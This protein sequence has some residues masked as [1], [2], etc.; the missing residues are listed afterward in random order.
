MAD[1]GILP[2]FLGERNQHGS[3]TYGVLLS[4]SGVVCLGWLSFS[5]VVDM[6][7]LLFCF[8]QAIE[9]CAFLHLRRTQPDMPRPFKIGVGLVGMCVMLA[10]PLM[11][12]FVIISFSSLTSLVIS[13]TLAALG[14]LVWYL[15]EFLKASKICIFENKPVHVKGTQ[16]IELLHLTSPSPNGA[17]VRAWRWRRLF[18]VSIPSHCLLR[19]STPLDSHCLMPLLPTYL[20]SSLPSCRSLSLS[21]RKQSLLYIHTH[22][23]MFDLDIVSICF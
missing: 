2:K 10:F 8:G 18:S 7:N 22:T 13:S 16:G 19:R 9:F 6:L 11:F 4:A 23:K 5:Q 20:P 15:L 21:P 12:I 17:E 3:P 14:V 1:R